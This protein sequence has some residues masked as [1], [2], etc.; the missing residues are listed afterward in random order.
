MLKLS[1]EV[2]ARTINIQ[3]RK[4][5]VLVN[6]A[7]R[8]YGLKQ[9]HVIITGPFLRSIQ[10]DTDAICQLRLQLEQPGQ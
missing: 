9:L 6:L 2:F 8:G 7:T 10:N 4:I 1:S 5:S 3:I